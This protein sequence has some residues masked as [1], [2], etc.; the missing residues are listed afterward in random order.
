MTRFVVLAVSH[1]RTVD[2]LHHLEVALSV[3]TTSFRVLIVRSDGQRACS[4]KSRGISDLRQNARLRVVKT[5]PESKGFLR[6]EAQASMAARKSPR[7]RPP[8]CFRAAIVTEPR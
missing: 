1:T 6:A 8:N 5:A 7:G 3:C 2:P 4:W